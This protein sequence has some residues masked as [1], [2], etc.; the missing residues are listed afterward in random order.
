MTLRHHATLIG[1]ATGSILIAL[2]LL[3]HVA[4]GQERLPC[5]PGKVLLR[6]LETE[7]GE[8]PFMTGKV[9]DELTATIYLDSVD[10]SWTLAVE[11]PDGIA[12][13][14]MGGS[15]LNPV[16]VVKPGQPL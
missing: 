9:N 10:K 12:C 16:L 7:Y 11:R 14:Y 8:R 15:G 1:L 3:S 2:A 6:Q 13:V 5:F 4:F